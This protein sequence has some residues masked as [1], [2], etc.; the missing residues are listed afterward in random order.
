MTDLTRPVTR[1]V[2]TGRGEPLVVTLTPEGLVIREPRRRSGFLLPYGVGFQ[3][4][5]RLH[6]DAEKRA[7]AAARKAK[8]STHPRGAR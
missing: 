5:V 6:V 3:L 4:A 1:K 2:V 8:R 7:K